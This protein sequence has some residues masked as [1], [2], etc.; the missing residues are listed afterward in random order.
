MQKENRKDTS[1]YRQLY[2]LVLPIAI[3]NLISAMVN[4]VDVLML[5]YV[6]ESAI[7]AVSLANQVM[8]VL[9]MFITGLTSGI[10]ML[11]AQ[12]WG[13]QDVKSIEKIFGISL[14]FSF[15]ITALFAFATAFFPQYIMRFF[16]P[17]AHLIELGASYLKVLSVSYL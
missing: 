9:F 10:A 7:A 13:K 1:F 16:T 14:R 8:F 6:S 15:P 12:Y 17:E 5:N 2:I 4:S 11:V 3:Q